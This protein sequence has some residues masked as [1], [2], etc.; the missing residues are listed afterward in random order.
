MIWSLQVTSA[1]EVLIGSHHDV[2]FD[3]IMTI[4]CRIKMSNSM[5]INLS[6]LNRMD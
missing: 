4:V 3:Y 1:L 6:F 5:I 2:V